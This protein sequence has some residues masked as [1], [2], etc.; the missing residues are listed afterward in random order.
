MTFRVNSYTRG[1]PVPYKRK[2]VRVPM[3]RQKP[4]NA[5]FSCDINCIY[6][7]SG[8]GNWSQACVVVSLFSS[9]WIQI[10]GSPSWTDTI[11]ETT[12]ILLKKA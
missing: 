6:S 11:Q 8:V 4:E 7:L 12:K 1:N 2:D 3:T 10:S 5:F 9:R